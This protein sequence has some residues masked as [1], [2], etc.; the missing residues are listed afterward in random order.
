[1]YLNF[2]Q[3]LSTQNKKRILKMSAHGSKVYG[4][5]E[6]GGTK[7]VC[8]MG[9]G[10]D[11]LN[12]EIRF[13]TTNPEETIGRAINYFK[14]QQ[15]KYSLEAIGV[16]SFGPVDLRPGSPTYGYITTTPKPGWKNT[17]FMGRLQRELNLPVYFETDVNAAAFGEYQWGA[18][19][20]LESLLYLTIGT[21]IGG[22]SIVNGRL[23]HG[24]N[25]IETGHILLPRDKERDPFEG[26]CPFHGDCLEGLASGPAIEKRWGKKAESLPADHPAWELETDYLAA[27]LVNFLLTLAPERII[28]GGGVMSEPYLFPMIRKKVK[29][30]LNNYIHLPEIIDHIDEYIVPPLL[31]K[32]TGI[33]GAIALAKTGSESQQSSY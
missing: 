22:G 21:G 17:E 8:A 15:K 13:P 9:S 29:K 10:P 6:A 4:G 25:H 31:G 26:I 7:F 27:G 18:G 16:G 28:M 30:L 23:L 12:N 5:I 20:N 1:M 14:E 32:H 11:D 2:P 24:F 3:S 19:Q 33:L